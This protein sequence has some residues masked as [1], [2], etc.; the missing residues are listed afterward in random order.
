MNKKPVSRRCFLQHT[1]LAAGG[2]VLAACT[3][4]KTIPDAGSESTL[5]PQDQELPDSSTGGKPLKILIVYD[6][7]YGNTQIIAE[8]LRDGVGSRHEVD[9]IRA[10]DADLDDLE[11]KDVLMVGSPTHGGLF[12]ESIKTFLAAIPEN[13]LANMSAAAFDTGSTTENQGWSGR[14]IIN[15][16]GYASPRIARELVKRGASVIRAETFFVLDTQGPLKEGEV[17]RARAWSAGVLEE[18]NK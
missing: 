4:E 18:L 6:T 17:E 16:L 13:G 10:V 12:I 15:L 5:A 1:A 2:I 11:N 8:A 14:F 3:P 7:V 9:L